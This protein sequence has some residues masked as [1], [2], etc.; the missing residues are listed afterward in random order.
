MVS[1]DI[2][3]QITGHLAKVVA[4]MLLFALAG[5]IAPGQRTPLPEGIIIGSVLVEAKETEKPWNAEFDIAIKELVDPVTARAK[6]F[7]NA[8]KIVTRANEEKTFVLILPAGTYSF[9][10]LEA[11]EVSYYLN[12]HLDVVPNTS[13]YVGKLELVWP[14]EDDPRTPRDPLTPK[15][16]IRVI[17]SQEKT[18]SSLQKEYPSVTANVTKRLMVKVHPLDWTKKW[19][20]RP[21]GFS[22][23]EDRV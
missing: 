11:G 22:G 7:K 14:S 12:V 3:K 15:A 1:L 13:L 19:P 6:S 4:T 21:H 23:P 2:S 10:Y 8:Y 16:R 17:D 20:S 18:I 5:C 9:V